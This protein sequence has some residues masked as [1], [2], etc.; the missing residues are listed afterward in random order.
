MSLKV[1]EAAD[2]DPVV[3]PERRDFLRGL[4]ASLRSVG[5]AGTAAL[6]AGTMVIA[7]S[8]LVPT[9]PVAQA[10]ETAPPS[11]LPSSVYSGSYLA[12]PQSNQWLSINSTPYYTYDSNGNPQYAT[13]VANYSID[14]CQTGPPYQCPNSIGQISSQPMS[15]LI[16]ANG[17]SAVVSQINATISGEVAQLNSL[18]QQETSNYNECETPGCQASWGTNI[19]AN[20]QLGLILNNAATYNQS[21][22][23][24]TTTTTTTT[25]TTSPPVTTTPTTNPTTTP[26]STLPSQSSQPAS[27]TATPGSPT[28]QPV[29]TT[30]HPTTTPGSTSPSQPAQT[31]TGNGSLSAAA[32]QAVAS[33][34]SGTTQ[35]SNTQIL[36]TSVQQGSSADST[37]VN[38][39][40]ITAP[41]IVINTS[42]STFT[43]SADYSTPSVTLSANQVTQVTPNSPPINTVE[44]GTISTESASGGVAASTAEQSV[45][46][47]VNDPISAKYIQANVT[48]N[49]QTVAQ[50]NVTKPNQ[51]ADNTSSN[52]NPPVVSPSETP[53]TNDDLGYAL[54]GTAVSAVAVGAASVAYDAAVT[55]AATIIAN[56]ELLLLLL[57]T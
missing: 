9:N 54:V 45:G 57:A 47:Q 42:F 56:P 22:P 48:V 3:I 29:T 12:Y 19:Q 31:V 30:T 8:A 46:V 26:G 1:A 55:A 11:S 27:P 44:T 41:S 40:Q 43:V 23:A 38:V 20:Y 10:D 6:V 7:G 37:V 16:A 53:Q 32:A 28:T 25:T 52:G 17:N 24:Q 15:I 13:Y 34:V 36:I 35:G 18:I 5:R 21:L 33:A 14:N 39:T 50:A 51:A 2:R 49:N 4:R